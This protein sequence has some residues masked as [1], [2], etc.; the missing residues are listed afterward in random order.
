MLNFGAFELVDELPPRKHADDMVWVDEWRGERKEKQRKSE[1]HEKR[2][3]KMRNIRIFPMCLDS[4]T[5]FSTISWVCR[6][7]KISMM[8]MIALGVCLFPEEKQQPILGGHRFRRKNDV[9]HWTY[10]KTHFTI[11]N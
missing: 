11:E 7:T 1:K 8:S 9:L 5:K 2:K 10:Q 3:R 6:C 4:H